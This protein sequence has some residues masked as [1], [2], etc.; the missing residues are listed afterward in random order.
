[1]ITE[2]VEFA[3]Y[4]Y[5]CSWC[6]TYTIMHICLLAERGPLHVPT[7]L[8]F[9]YGTKMQLNKGK[10]SV[11]G[12]CVVSRMKPVFICQCV[13]WQTVDVAGDE[14]AALCFA[15]SAY[16]PLDYLPTMG[17]TNGQDYPL[18]TKLFNILLLHS[19]IILTLPYICAQIPY[20]EWLHCCY[21]CTAC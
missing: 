5:L 19:F 11:Y 12:I 10:I 21:L 15:N 13:S 6:C 8:L 18:R 3:V 9:S 2:I 7:L 14:V 20:T 16:L 1:M 17:K 4:I